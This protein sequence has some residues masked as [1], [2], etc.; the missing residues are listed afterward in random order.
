MKK[1]KIA[2]QTKV[3]AAA[4]LAVFQ[5]SV[6]HAQANNDALKLD[7][8]VVTGSAT[9]GSKMKQ[10]LSISTLDSEQLTNTVASSSADLLRSVPGVRA[11]SS[12]GEGNA[13]VTVRGVPISAGGSRYV[14][15]QEDGLPVLQMGDFNFVTPDMFLR[16]SLGTDGLEVVR[17]GSASTM[18]TNAPGGI[19]N[20]I[21]KT[22]DVEGGTISATTNVSGPSQRRVDFG[23]G[24]ATSDTSSVYLSGFVRSGE[25]PRDTHGVN[26]ESGG[27][28]K[29][30]FNKDLGG[31][32][33]VKLHA[34]LLD[35][36]TP[37]LMASPVNT[38]N[39]QIV[40]LP[41]VDPRTFS[42]YASNLPAIS[43]YGMH[44][45]A[46]SM[47]EGLRSKSTAIGSE[48]NLNL[49]DGWTLND[50]FRISNNSGGFNGIMPGNYA[51][52]AL[53]A[54]GASSYTAL[55]LGA[56]F[57]DVGLAVNDLKLSK[58]HALQDG[59]KLTT[60]AGVFASSQKLDIDWEIGGFNAPLVPAANSTYGSYT[61]WYKRHI[62]Q[63][64][65]TV[66]PYAAL[67]W[68]KGAWVL[69]GSVRMDRQ[70]VTGTYNANGDSLGAR[71]VDYKSNFNAYSFGANY[72]LDKNTALFARI[73]D[74]ASFNSDRVL[75]QESTSKCGLTCFVGKTVPVNEVKQYE[76][77][78][79]N[80]NG[81]LSTFV[82]FFLAKT[83]ESNYD[84]T[85]GTTSFTK[86]SAKGV[87]LN[88]PGYR[89]GWLV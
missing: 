14:Q 9:G 74:G 40:A 36:K 33:S 75:F 4:A 62:N 20:F 32:N 43:Q 52:N 22:G 56:K 71:G 84:L 78:V 79:K 82:T 63:T 89:G 28:F 57:N 42:P 35:D 50:K 44:G 68:E 67:N 5:L 3:A 21:S 2:T 13:N 16:S 73:S 41:G 1:Q 48:I 46:A 45:G 8:V 65:N 10:S 17:G 70:S 49:G 61:S 23:Y 88:R 30:S 29:A 76:A 37:T 39:G 12:G 53:P 69:D 11:E 59:A 19:I 25:G 34:K 51:D 54:S 87:E 80:K 66:S 18:A 77:G 6:A 26:M 85:T 83:D 86:Y 81:N 64:Y 24:K 27:Q 47:N 31:G 72:N 55:F 7:E 38:V 60:T 58:K 15:F